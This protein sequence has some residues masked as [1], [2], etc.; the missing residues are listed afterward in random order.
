MKDGKAN[1]QVALTLYSL[2]KQ[3]NSGNADEFQDNKTNTDPIKYAVWAQQTEKSSFR[4]QLEYIILVGQC[5]IQFMETV[6][7]V[8][9]GVIQ[10]INIDV[11]SQE[12]PFAKNVPLPARP[13]DSEYLAGLS[14]MDKRMHA[15]Y[16]QI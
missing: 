4:C 14:G 13:D 11:A 16:A 15:L 2:F 8:A 1:E 9:S 6:K 7:G 3:I 10:E 12:N 5:D